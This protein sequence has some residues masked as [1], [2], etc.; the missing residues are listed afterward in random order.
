MINESSKIISN[1]EDL[2]GYIINIKELSISQL[3]QIKTTAKS[4]KHW[5][6]VSMFVFSDESFIA[7]QTN[8]M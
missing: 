7:V 3:S 5:L 4:E 6:S 8:N 1:G 2:P